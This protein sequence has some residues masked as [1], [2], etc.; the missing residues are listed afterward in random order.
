MQ[1]SVVRRLILFCAV[2][3][4]PA[5]VFAQEATLTGTVADSSG[6]VLP[7]VTVQAV[8]EATGNSFEAVTDGLG[9]YRLA[10]RVGSY[11]MVAQLAG[12]SSVNRTGVNLLVGE[13]RTVNLQLAPSS[14]Q[15]TVT[16]SCSD[17]GASWRL[18]VRVSPTSRFTPARFTELKPAS[19]ATIR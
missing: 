1:S 4:L 13:T 18:T 15:E 10:V 14:L 6:A 11:R 8:N 2:L 5:M 9:V 16:V 19:W 3:A 7:G 12:F 17:E